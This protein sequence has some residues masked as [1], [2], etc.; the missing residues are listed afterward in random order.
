MI[1]KTTRALSILA[2][3]ALTIGSFHPAVHARTIMASAG[4][5]VNAGDYGCFWLSGSSMTNG[6]G[7]TVRLETSLPVDAAGWVTV[8]V[9]AQ[10]AGPGNNVGCEAVAMDWT[11]TSFWGWGQVWLPAFG[12]AQSIHTTTWV[13]SGGGLF[14]Y[15]DVQPNG[16]VNLINY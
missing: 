14:V 7:Y 11:L 3:A 1:N 15:C 12:S 10:G 2:A 8:N 13:P 5:A 16:R 9:S 4:R 6:C